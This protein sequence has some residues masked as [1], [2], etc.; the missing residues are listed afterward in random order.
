MSQEKDWEK[1]IHDGLARVTGALGPSTQQRTPS[2]PTRQEPPAWLGQFVGAGLLAVVAS[3]TGVELLFVPSI[4]LA[5]WGVITFASRR[6]AP[7]LQQDAGPQ[8]GMGTTIA[9]DAVIEPGAVVEHGVTI[10]A[11]ATLRAGAV[12]RMGATVEAGAT[13]ERGAVLQWGATLGRDAVL[14]EGAVLR[15]GATVGQAARVERAAIVGWGVTIGDGAQVGTGAYL[16]SGVTVQ[17]GAAVPAHRRLGPGSEVHATGTRP[18]LPARKAAPAPAA[19]PRDARIDAVCDRLDRELRGSSEQVRTFLGAPDETVSSLRRTCHEILRREREL[20][21]E[22]DEATLA[23]LDAER[24]AIEARIAATSD[25]SVRRSF[26]AAASAIAEQRRQREH[27]AAAATRLE[28][29]HTRLVW[30]LESMAAQLVRLRSTGAVTTDATLERSVAELR[31]GMDAI[32]DA[33]TDVSD[34]DRA[35]LAEAGGPAIDGDAISS[36]ATRTPTRD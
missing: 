33:L 28:A 9:P 2:L 21:A 6:K 26:E 27:I 11:G 20:R 23:Q 7:A 12:V 34:A 13:V 14:E 31:A 35:A 1:A 10:G 19:D 15:W 17:S 4:A 5:A 16:S 32:A 8:I 29:E 36:P 22:S 30:T 25:A 18:A 24:G 3:V